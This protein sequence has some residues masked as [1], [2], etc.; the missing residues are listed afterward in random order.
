M[1]KTLIIYFEEGRA[2]REDIIKGNLKDNIKKI[3]AKLLEK[4]NPS[5]SDFVVVREEYVHSE[6]LPLTP[7]KYELFSKYNIERGSG[8]AYISIPIFVISYENRLEGGE[9]IDSKIAVIAPYINEE[10]TN[11]IIKQM[12]LRDSY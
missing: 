1:D 11:N 8:V 9:Y 12:S 3:V 7:E 5:S 2:I 6:K 10:T 4:W